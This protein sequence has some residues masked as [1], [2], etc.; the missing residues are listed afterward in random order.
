MDHLVDLHPLVLPEA[1]NPA[2]K[3]QSHPV[4]ARISA[5]G[6]TSGKR[7]SIQFARKVR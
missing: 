5:V 2:A 4:H 7:V 1:K 6:R 3:S